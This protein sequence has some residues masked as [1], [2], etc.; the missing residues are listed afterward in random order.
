MSTA[1]V[2]APMLLNRMVVP[3]IAPPSRRPT[4]R[5]EPLILARGRMLA[6]SRAG[7]PLA[8]YGGAR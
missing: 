8:T 4:R 5:P 2:T 6:G 7:S 3:D 1:T